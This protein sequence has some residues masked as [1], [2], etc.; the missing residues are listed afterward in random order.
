[1]PLIWTLSM[2]TSQKLAVSVI[3][4]LALITIAFE[5]V[6]TVKLYQESFVLTNLYSYLEFEIAIIVSML[7]T[8]R[9]LISNS[10]KNREYRRAFWSRITLRSYQSSHSGYS[11]HSYD[12]RSRAGNSSQ[13]IATPTESEEVPPLPETSKDEASPLENEVD[14]RLNQRSGP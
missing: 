3:C 6:R 8:Y 4:S 12:R 2:R 7:P 10:E 14:G 9:F 1:M 11:M 13:A 5:V